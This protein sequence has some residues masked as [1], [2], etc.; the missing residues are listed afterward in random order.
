[1]KLILMGPQGSGK[2]THAEII[3]KKLNIAHIS[4]GDL[5]RSASGSLKEE[6]DSYINSGKLVPDE[7]TIKILK[8]KL[9]KKECK[10]GFILDGFPRNLSQAKALDSITSIDKVVV[11]LI[12]DKE[13]IKRI[14]SRLS[15][16]KC[17]KVFNILTNPPKKE[18]VCDICSSQLTKRKDDS[19]ESL[20]KRLEIYHKE[21]EK[22]ISYY[23]K[24][25][26]V[27]INGERSIGAVEKDILSALLESSL[28]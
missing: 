1:M 3:S 6:I 23:P 28:K 22:V 18:N 7:L 16:S 13:S 19:E 20:K 12:S 17:G 9:S 14:S 4:T 2:G 10:N 25:K 26:I 8:E 21:T 5:F 24:E 27:E 11:I 15:C